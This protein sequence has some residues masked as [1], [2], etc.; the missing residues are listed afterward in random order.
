[1][2]SHA[3]SLPQ[4][5]RELLVGSVV[6]GTVRRTGD[7]VRINLLARTCA[8]GRVYW[9]RS[10]EITGTTAENAIRL[11]A[12]S[13]VRAARVPASPEEHL[14]LE[15][16]V[17]LGSNRGSPTC[18]AA[19]TR[20]DEPRPSGARPPSTT[21][22]RSPPTARTRRPGPGSRTL[23]ILARRD[24]WSAPDGS[25]CRPRAGERAAVP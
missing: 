13:L 9:S 16:I 22:S 12:R 2:T 6:T 23:E 1:M 17:A 15:W 7:R 11:F 18:A 20:T 3:D 25:G 19:T 21:G 5:G 14:A 4:I 10:E 24:Q 8:D